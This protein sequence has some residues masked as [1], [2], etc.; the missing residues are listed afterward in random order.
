MKTVK[1]FFL[2]ASLAFFL[3]ACSE[4]DEELITVE[5][6]IFTFSINAPITVEGLINTADREII[7]PVDRA[8]NVSNLF[9]TATFS[10][11]A[12]LSPSIEDGVDFS[13]RAVDF[14]LTL[15]GETVV[16]TVVIDVDY[17]SLP[18][19]AQP[20][21]RVFDGEGIGAACALGPNSKDVLF[22]NQAGTEYAQIVENSIVGYLGLQDPNGPISDCPY[23]AV[24]AAHAFGDNI[25]VYPLN[26]TSWASLKGNE[27]PADEKP[28]SEGWAGEHPFQN[29]NPGVSSGH[30]YTNNRVV[31]FSGDGTQ[32]VVYD[33]SGPDFGDPKSLDVWG[34]SLW[35]GT[36]PFDAVGP[37]LQI[38]TDLNPLFEAVVSNEIDYVQILFD[39]AGKEFVFYHGTYGF[40][41]VFNIAED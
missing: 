5:P 23:I 21:F 25:Y 29:M 20:W 1:H 19:V 40:S 18:P 10:E 38:Q 32:W 13:A 3:A 24:G 26:G 37:A 4:S 28:L 33:P 16:Y 15:N 17:P 39:Q 9:G 35:G 12:T 30:Y 11:G 34:G 6:E 27:L 14:T 41:E 7:I 8:T 2:L 31:H 22:F 36:L